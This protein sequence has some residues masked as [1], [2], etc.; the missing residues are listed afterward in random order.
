MSTKC[1]ECNHEIFHIAPQGE[2]GPPAVS[3]DDPKIEQTSMGLLVVC[4]KCEAKNAIS[5]F[6]ENGLSVSRITHL[7]N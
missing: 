3:T 1:L 5:T 2:N 6:E 7:I 4:P